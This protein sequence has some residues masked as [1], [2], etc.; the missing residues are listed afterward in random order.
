MDRQALNDGS[1][2]W[3]DLDQAEHLADGTKDQSALWRTSEGQWMLGMGK[4]ILARGLTFWHT[5]WTCIDVEAAAGWFVKHG[6][7]P[8]PLL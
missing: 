3:F 6:L 4:L 1:G 2:R 7:E 5:D 8:H